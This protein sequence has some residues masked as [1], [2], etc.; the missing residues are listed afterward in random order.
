MN[1]IAPLMFEWDDESMV[2][3]NPR[4]AEN[5]YVVGER[6]RLV[7]HEE[8]STASHNHFFACVKDAFDNLP[9]DREEQ[10]ATP[11]HLRKWCLIQAGYRDQRT[12][13]CASQAEALRV[14]AFIRPIDDYAVV[15]AR[16]ATVIE[17]KAK[18]QSGRAMGK[19]VF[20]ES[21]D[22]V[23]DILAGMVKI[24]AE[25]LERNAGQAA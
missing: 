7:P 4:R 16:E 22:K 24:D 20:Q 14:A 6:Y 25:T 1:A 15:V 3:L 17:W 13:V 18:S 10:F 5:M 23:L 11:E 9:E 8:R 19:K 21:K 2:P 12:I